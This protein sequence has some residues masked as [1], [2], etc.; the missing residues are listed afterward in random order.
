VTGSAWAIAVLSVACV[1]VPSLPWISSTRGTV[2]M[3]GV[4]TRD[5]AVVLLP[6]LVGAVIAVPAALGAVGAARRR[7]HGLWMV[8]ALALL[9]QITMSLE[10]LAA[11]RRLSSSRAG[12]PKIGWYIDVG[13][14]TFGAI[15]LA[16]GGFVVVAALRHRARTT[17]A[18][19]Q[20]GVMLAAL[21][22]GAIVIWL[23]SRDQVFMA[24]WVTG[25]FLPPLS[26]VALVAS[27]IVI[28]VGVCG[29]MSSVLARRDRAVSVGVVA[30]WGAFL[31][32]PWTEAVATRIRMGSSDSTPWTFWLGTAIALV[33]G[34]ALIGWTASP[35]TRG[36]R[37]PAARATPSMER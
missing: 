29:P 8:G 16:I 35:R 12:S 18:R 37:R 14:V 9:G 13:V 28:V 34:L 17:S 26:R 24:R 32:V 15:A 3:Y 6:R 30:G 22:F 27:W 33:G 2:T 20:P 7:R 31:A 25:G 11:G 4:A 19:A 21:A 1:V 10:W 23:L 5:G 36:P